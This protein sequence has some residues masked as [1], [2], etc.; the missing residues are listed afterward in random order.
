M[1]RLLSVS[2]GIALLVLAMLSSVA[3]GANYCLDAKN[4]DRCPDI[5]HT[6]HQAFMDD[7]KAC[8]DLNKGSL[9]IASGSFFKD[10]SK[11]AFLAGGPAPAFTPSGRWTVPNSANAASCSNVACHNIP[12]GTFTYYIWDWGIDE[13]VP[14]TVNY[15]GMSNATALWQDN[16]ATNCNSCH[17]NPPKSGYVWHSG[18]HGNFMPGA[19]NC[20][21][22]HPDARS[23]VAADGRTILSNYITAPSQHKN[24]T[25]DVVAKFSSKCFGCH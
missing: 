22:C 1:K 11:G 14:V 6:K 19:N 25:V 2:S 16:T 20:E 18:V 12:A 7:C 5:M 17:G 23:N 21:T 9:F 3:G 10:S 8:H 4:N 15:G 24:G 13:A